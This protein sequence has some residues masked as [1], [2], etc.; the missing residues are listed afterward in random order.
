MV[1]S[2]LKKV[3]EIIFQTKKYII[4]DNYSLYLS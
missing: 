2:T 3:T 1:G 4:E